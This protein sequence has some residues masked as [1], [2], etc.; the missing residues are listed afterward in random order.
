MGGKAGLF[1]V[2]G[3]SMIFM[4][5]GVNFNNISTRSIDNVTKYYAE[6]KMY[7][8]AAGIVNIMVNE[9]YDDAS[10]ADGTYNYTY[11]D[12]KITATL[13]TTDSYKNI[14]ELV[15][16]AKFNE[17]ASYNLYSNYADSTKT[18]KVVLK[19][20]M[21]SKF[22]YFSDK[23]AP[24]GSVIYW[25]TA[26]TVWGPFHTN[27]NLN[28]SGNPVFFGAATIGGTVKKASGVTSNPKFLGGK[29]ENISIK[30]PTGGV[31]NVITKSST[32]SQFTSGKSTVYFEFRGDS[33]R[34]RYATSGTG[35]TWTY[36][37]L[38]TFAPTG[39]I[40][41]NNANVRI[42]GK[43]KGSYS[44]VASGTQ[45]STT[46]GNIYI[47][48]DIYYNTDPKTTS[49]SLDMLGIVAKNSVIITNNSA[50]NSNV[51]I[52]AAIYCESGSFTAESYST[53]GPSGFIDLYGGMTQST[54]GAVGLVGGSNGFSKRY[55]YDPR[56][57]LSYPP[58][59]P[60]CGVFEI[61]SWFE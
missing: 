31:S 57:L 40:Y 30:I 48:D 47:D 60:G 20:S 16:T 33:I 13:T 51:K 12:C 39:V 7:H 35:S 59:Y 19:P 58:Y 2:L 1:V 5:M 44:L 27:D 61:A 9:L 46:Q 43:V 32:T 29:L 18:I 15:C 54:R 24:T 23:E 8:A 11:S 50:N 53:R 21:F 52:Q 3:F 28:V 14:R 34:Y 26:D 37:L 17:K 36:K 38:S 41:A 56:L 49:S 4:A 25:A 10:F 42:S 6:T 45:S 22:A 55:R